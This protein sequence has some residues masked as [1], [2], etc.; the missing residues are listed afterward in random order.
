MNSEIIENKRIKELYTRIKHKSGLTICLYPMREYSTA[1]AIFGAKYGSIDTTF[2]TKNDADYVTVPEGIAHYL[3]HKL[4]E[5]DDCDA[6]EQYA[7]TGA[8]ANAYTTFDSTAYYFSCTRE[9]EENLRILL[10]FV[11]NPY[12]TDESVQKEQGIISQEIK[13]YL[14]DPGWR[15]F[16]N[17]LCAVYHNNPVRIDIAGTTESIA[18]ID[19]E[20]L[21][22]C[23][24]A[25]YN[26]NNMVLSVAGNFNP[27]DVIRICDE[28]LKPSDNQELDIIIP[29]EPYTVKEKR[30]VQ[31]LYCAVPLFQLAF[32]MPNYEGYENT[33][34]FIIYN[35]LFEMA[36]GSS[37]PF[38]SRLYESG[39]INDTFH[40]GVFNGRGFFLPVADGESRDPDR[41]T[42]KIID[43]LNRLK[44]T[45]LPRDEFEIV[46]KMTY[47]ELIGTFNNVGAVAKSVMQAEFN[48]LNAYENVEITASVTYEDVTEALQRLDTENYSLSI[49]E[50]LEK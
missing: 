31:K 8:S 10:N 12:F 1:F 9:F 32:K 35:M 16:F 34:N 36:L 3:E 14:D 6:L 42:K 15:V 28:L 47:G 22:R 30:C 2:R 39:L 11:Q 46:K 21:Y 4:F 27:E 43:E 44:K 38:F 45:G 37:S 41:V 13:I 19:K 24:N 26:L 18:K 29:E 48:G 17:G 49:I 5:N 23:Y 25:F 7:K 20:L 33:R 50:P 40:V